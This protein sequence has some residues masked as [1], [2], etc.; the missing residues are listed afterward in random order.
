MAKEE[1]LPWL[2]LEF[3]EN[4]L[5]KAKND[6]SIR[7]IDIFSKPATAKGDNYTS[8]MYRILLEISCKQA[9]GQEV[10]KKTSLIVKVAPTGDTLKKD[11]IEKSMIF[12]TE[13]SMM[14]NLLKKMND[15]V[16]PDHILGARIFYV[17]KEHPVFLVIEDLAPLGFRM[18]DRQ[19]GLDLTHC[20]LAMRGLARFHASSLAICEKEPN[21]KT[22]YTRGIYYNGHPPELTSFFSL[23][24]K[25]LAAQVKNWPNFEKYAEK[26]DKI[27]DKLYFETCKVIKQRDDEFNV[28]N[29]GDFW[30]NNMMFRYNEERKPIDH[31]FVDFQLCVYGSPAL[32]LQYFLSTSPN[33]EVYENDRETLIKEYYSTLCNMMKQ[34][35]CKTSPPSMEKLQKRINDYE[36]VAMISSFA[37]LPLVLI[38]RNEAK[39]INEIMGTDGGYDDSAYKTDIYR[40]VICKRIPYYDQ[41]GL[42]DI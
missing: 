35:D 17:R 31:I 33:N 38:D 18:A 5:R 41:L 32:D 24:V 8:D 11:L 14:M 28:I 1:T 40:K 34:L 4:I 30:V 22:I 37:I 15:L 23:G 39:D 3:L 12:D 19:A 36:I 21:Q 26:I 29:H 6:D 42:L 25:S 20:L 13:M 10:T 27:S 7:V 16:G 9:G 2:N